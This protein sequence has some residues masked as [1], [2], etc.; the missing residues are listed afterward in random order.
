MNS[1]KIKNLRSIENTGKIPLN[2]LTILL[3]Q[4][5]SGKS[6][7]LRLFPLL[8]QS[9]ETRTSGPILWFGDYVDF[10]DF[11]IAIR[12]GEKEMSFQFEFTI[13][14]HSTTGIKGMRR[15]VSNKW[16]LNQVK[17][18]TFIFNLSIMTNKEN[19]TYI[20][21]FNLCFFDHKIE[22]LFNPK[23]KITFYSVNCENLTNI[24]EKMELNLDKGIIPYFFPPL[25]DNY[26]TEIGLMPYK[27]L[28]SFLRNKLDSDISDDTIN[29]IIFD[30]EICSN[31]SF[32]KKLI[33]KASKYSKTWAEIVK[34]W[35]LNHSDFKKYRNLIIANNYLDLLSI[36]N[37]YLINS[38]R[39]FHYIKPLRATAERSYRKQ[40]LAVSR[41]DSTG[42]N[43]SMFIENLPS[44]KTEDFQNWIKDSFGFYPYTKREGLNIELKLTDIKTGNDF[45]IA[46]RGFGF[47]QILPIITQLWS[48]ID[49]N[50]NIKKKLKL[51]KVPVIL[52]IE[53]P[54]LHLHPALQSQLIDC[55]IKSIQFAKEKGVEL[56]L[57]LETHSQTIVNR[58][59]HRIANNDLSEK[60]VSIVLFELESGED[61]SSVISS[62]YNKQGFLENWPIGFFDPKE[63]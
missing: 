3:G 28:D 15:K 51:Y 19:I 5:S 16:L 50:I 8:K 12:K 60:D 54:E 42:K 44:K 4:N 21:K 24:M 31:A 53:Q 52:A 30:T 46:D 14:L 10:G 39:N 41:V 61:K 18:T 35:H 27:K 11:D 6:T 56:K 63:I 34:T 47:S 26:S 58:I 48:I 1:I 7:F 38:I 43:L 29:E 45:N 23:G 36:L 9:I 57:I 40:D 22:M 49:E 17:N 62:N 32:L 2:S 20:N 25:D 55:F 37:D 33:S 59:G 13:A